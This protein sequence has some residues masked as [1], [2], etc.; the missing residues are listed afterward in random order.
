[1][2][3]PNTPTAT[4]CDT[5]QRSYVHNTV[6]MCAPRQHISHLTPPLLLLLLHALQHLALSLPAQLTSADHHLDS[7]TN[8]QRQSEREREATAHIHTDRQWLSGQSC[9]A[10][11][12]V[13]GVTAQD[14]LY[15]TH[16]A[17]PSTSQS[18]APQTPYKLLFHS[19]HDITQHAHTHLV[20]GE[21]HCSQV[22]QQ[23]SVADVATDV[24]PLT[25]ARLNTLSGI[26][27]WVF[28]VCCGECVVLWCVCGRLFG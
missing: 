2:A 19:P 27:L 21:A 26:H 17:C 20:V 24:Q 11:A 23:A 9:W 10:L 22:L 14:S 6:H 1:M 28:G 12:W 3:Q 15:P 4:P 8:L 18:N 25:D 5:R 7:K 13:S 16:H